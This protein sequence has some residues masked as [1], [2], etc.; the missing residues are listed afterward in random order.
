MQVRKI[1]TDAEWKEL[2]NL[3]SFWLSKTVKNVISIVQ[4]ESVEKKYIDDVI[5]M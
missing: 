1:E 2:L 3:V 5:A 4:S